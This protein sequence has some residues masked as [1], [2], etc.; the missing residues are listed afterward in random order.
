VAPDAK[1]ERLNLV[2]PTCGW[3]PAR[4]DPALVE[5]RQSV[6]QETG[7]PG[8][9]T[10]T[11]VH[12][13]RGADHLGSLLKV[14]KAVEAAIDEHERTMPVR[15]KPSSR[16][17]SSPTIPQQAEMTFEREQPAPRARAPG[18]L[19]EQHTRGDDLGLRLRGEQLAAGVRFVRMVQEGTYDLVVANPPY[20]GTSKLADAKYVRA[21]LPLGKADLYAAFLLR[22]LELVRPRAACRAMLTMRNWMF[23]KQYSGL[24]EDPEPATDHLSF[25]LG[26]ALGRFGAEGSRA[27]S[28]RHG[29]P[30][31]CAARR[32]LFLDGTL[33]QP[34][35]DRATAW[36]TPRP[37]PL[38]AAW[39]EHRAAIDTRAH[40]RTWLAHG[41]LQGR[42]QG[43]VREPAHPLAALVREQDLR[44]LGEHPPHERQTLRALLADHLLPT[45]SAWTAS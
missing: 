23:I 9:L 18:E 21:A 42:A 17:C 43:H 35:G 41:L 14:D 16:T 7:I 37:A 19:P 6:E 8:A 26:V 2:A 30:L 33:A 40:L 25:A 44:R 29:G 15:F 20:Q 38:L 28:T 24:R 10:D 11:L 12:A 45:Q 3:Q 27:S 22:G 1:P 13:L 36:A 39:A 5:L 31:P 4:H 34:T 32:P